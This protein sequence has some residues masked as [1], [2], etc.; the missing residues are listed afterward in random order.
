MFHPQ[1]NWKY[2]SIASSLRLS[3]VSS[4]KELKV[5]FMKKRVDTAREEFHPQRNWKIGEK[6]QSLPNPANWFHPQRNWKFYRMD[7]DVIPYC[8]WFHPQRN[9][10]PISN[11]INLTIHVTSRFILKGIESSKFGKETANSKLSFILKELKVYEGVV[12]HRIVTVSS[13]K[14]LKVEQR[15]YKWGDRDVS[16]ILKGIESLFCHDCHKLPLLLFHPQRNW[17]LAYD[18][19]RDTVERGFIL[20][21]IESA[22][23]IIDVQSWKFIPVSSSKELKVSVWLNASRGN[24]WGVSSSKELKDCS[25]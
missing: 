13:S 16:F 15:K 8:T 14:E 19:V 1:R 7:I 23:C 2:N 11:V 24:P 9:W 25:V 17:K 5:D 20:K 6:C 22:S 3:L 18:T 12:Q 4:S 21:G 10:K